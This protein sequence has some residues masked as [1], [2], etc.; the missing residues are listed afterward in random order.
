MRLF[1]VMLVLLPWSQNPTTKPSQSQQRQSRPA[2]EPTATD[3]RGTEQSPL[4]IKTLPTVKSKAETDQDTEDRD[5]KSSHD[6]WLVVFSGVLAVSAIF[7]LGVYGYQAKKLRET[8]KSAGE[9]SRAM[10]RHIEEAARSADAMERIANKIEAGN[11]AVMRAYLT[12]NIG[13]AI[14][15]Q[16]RGPGQADLKFEAKPQLVNTRNTQARKVRI[17]KKAAIL[18]SP[19]PHDFRYSEISEQ[20]NEP[21]ATV[22]GHQSYIISAIVPD[23]VPDADIQAVKEGS[24]QALHIWGVVTYED[25]FGDTH[26]TQFGQLLTWLP[27][28]QV[29]GYFTPGQNDAD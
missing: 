26:T 8:V 7:Q 25:I 12:V 6:W 28:G 15:Q 3:R 10:E 2:Q 27:D 24:E 16:R 21:F 4:V 14:Y 20:L 18:A 5:Q 13:S 1:L 17:R 23:D 29:Y 9:Q 11:K 19:L 22:A